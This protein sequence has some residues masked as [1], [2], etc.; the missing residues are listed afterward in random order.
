MIEDLL[1]TNYLLRDNFLRLFLV[2]SGLIFLRY[3]LLSAAFHQAFRISMR[4]AL[5]NRDLIRAPLNRSQAKKEIWY[6][7]VS[8]VIF[9]LTA[10][11]MIIGWQK[12][13]IKLYTSSDPGYPWWYI[14]V[15]LIGVLF[16]HDTYYYWM[17]RLFHHKSVYKLVHRVHHKSI[18]T[19]AFTSFSFHP[20]ESLA[21]AIIIPLLLL[22]I[23]LHFYAFIALLVFMT[24]SA[25][26]NHLGVEVYPSGKF[27]A[28]LGKWLIGATH[29]DQHHRKFLV[30]YG[31]YFTF[32]DR[33]MGTEASDFE[34][35]FNK[36]V[37][38]AVQ[39]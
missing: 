37:Q 39:D 15:S 8:S 25:I 27:G 1:T 13:Y 32:W 9:A 5:G 12:G 30:N 16:L 19:S 14:P 29:H 7:F 2:L 4:S 33:W 20:Y 35:N 31:L 23:P 36:A 21:Q 18:K 6:S 3:I 17:H 22:L 11:A 24:V 38:K 26:I 28:W 34:D 10:I